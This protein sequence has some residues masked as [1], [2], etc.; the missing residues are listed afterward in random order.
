MS[1]ANNALAS[2]PGTQQGPPC[3]EYWS[4]DAVFIGVANRVVNVPNNTLYAIGP[5]LR[6]T[7]YFTIE[8]AF[9]G[10]AGTAL[11]FDSQDCGYVFK[12]GE[13]YLVYAYRNNQQL[14]VKV[15]R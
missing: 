10:V 1:F 14:E 3:L 5:Y 11:V 8:E 4:S 12:E 15:A 6:T 9:K 7:A 2:C 13:R